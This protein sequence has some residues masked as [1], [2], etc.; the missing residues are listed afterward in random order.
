MRESVEAAAVVLGSRA[1]FSSIQARLMPRENAFREKLLGVDLNQI[2]ATV[3]P[4]L[5][6]FLSGA[7]SE[8][9]AIVLRKWVTAAARHSAA[10]AELI[11]LREQ[12]ACSAAMQAACECLCDLYGMH[13][14]EDDLRGAL[15]MADK[16]KGLLRIEFISSISSVGVCW[17]VYDKFVHS[18]CGNFC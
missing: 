10:T 13:N 3:R 14:V 5:D 8:T 2:L 6:K 11:L 18:C 17:I 12:T 1:D 9:L 15:L 16:F 7:S 4:R